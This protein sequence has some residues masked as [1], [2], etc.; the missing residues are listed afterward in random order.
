MVGGLH[1][2]ACIS[3]AWAGTKKSPPDTLLQIG[4]SKIA[5]ARAEVMQLLDVLWLHTNRLATIL[6]TF[7]LSIFQAFSF[8][9]PFAVWQGR[10]L[11]SLHPK[12]VPK[13]ISGKL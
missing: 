1:F 3:F 2:L 12:L 6:V 11:G 7:A 4:R 10:S 8:V 13:D 5:F 9:L